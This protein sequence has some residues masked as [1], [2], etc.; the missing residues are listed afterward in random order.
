M[1]CKNNDP[2]NGFQIT[3][4]YANTTIRHE[5]ESVYARNVAIVVNHGTMDNYYAFSASPT[6]A[7]SFYYQ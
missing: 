4:T 5:R 2:Q 3:L 6:V 1:S 7:W